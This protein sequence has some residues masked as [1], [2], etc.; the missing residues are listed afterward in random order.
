MRMTQ[1]FSKLCPLIQKETRTLI[2]RLL[3]Q[4]SILFMMYVNI[5]FGTDHI[6]AVWRRLRI[7]IGF[8]FEDEIERD[9]ASVHNVNEGF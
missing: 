4:F 1:A 8:Y 5:Y 7:I 2:S 6:V 9:K 3:R